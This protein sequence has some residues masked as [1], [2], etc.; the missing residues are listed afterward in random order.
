MTDYIEEMM[1]TAEMNKQIMCE[2]TCKGSGL[3][4]SFCE[5]YKSKKLV[6]PPFTPDKQLEI[7]KLIVSETIQTIEI[8]KVGKFYTVETLE[9]S[10]KPIQDFAQ[11]LAQLTVELM[12]TG[13]LDKQKVKEILE[14]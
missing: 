1:K 7:I 5:H 10:C 3:C 12:K 13:E 2:W 14:G 8:D 11:A 6:Y 9:Y 4:S